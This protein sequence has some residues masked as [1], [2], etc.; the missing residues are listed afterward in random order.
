MYING[1][2]VDGRWPSGGYRDSVPT[3]FNPESDSLTIV[4]GDSSGYWC[5]IYFNDDEISLNHFRCVGQEP[6]ANWQDPSFDDS[7]WPLAVRN[8]LG[9]WG[10]G[11]GRIW[12]RYHKVTSSPCDDTSQLY[13]GDTI[14]HHYYYYFH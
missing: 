10:T 8:N 4:A 6:P 13:Q 11:G 14:T 2:S 3:L 12:C 9:F 7:G 1:R 5:K